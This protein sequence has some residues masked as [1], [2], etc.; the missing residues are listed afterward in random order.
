MVEGVGSAT[1]SQCWR[2]DIPNN[3]FSNSASGEMVDFLMIQKRINMDLN[4]TLSLPA[5]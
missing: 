3:D 2:M 5:I 1:F 4:E